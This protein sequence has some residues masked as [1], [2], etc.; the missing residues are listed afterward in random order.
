MAQA[1]IQIGERQAKLPVRPPA[2]ASQT[3]S[4]VAASPPSG[5]AAT[6]S[7]EACQGSGEIWLLDRHAGAVWM[8]CGCGAAR[9]GA[10]SASWL[11]IVCYPCVAVGL[12]ASAFFLL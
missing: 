6:E 2:R 9:D 7:C 10:M 3:R 4:R 5:L 11:T 1:R 8:P 12:C